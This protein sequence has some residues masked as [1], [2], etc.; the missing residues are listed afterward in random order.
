GDLAARRGEVDRA[1]REAEDLEGLVVAAALDVLGEPDQRLA[2]VGQAVVARAVVV[3]L[4]RAPEATRRAVRATAVDVRLAVVED[5]VR[6]RGPARAVADAAQTV[7]AD[8]AVVA[9]RAPGA[10]APTV[11]VRL[12][13]V[14]DAVV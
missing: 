6:A 4:T 7:A 10:R 14:E 8:V 12:G 2:L 13:A 3:A 1:R 11:R 9:Q 5:P